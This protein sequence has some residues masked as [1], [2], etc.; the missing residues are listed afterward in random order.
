MMRS[1]GPIGGELRQHLRE[2]T[3]GAHHRI[4]HHR[5]M[6]P[7]IHGDITCREY[8][9]ILLALYGLHRPV[10]RALTQHFGEPPPDRSGRLAMDLDLIGRKVDLD[11]FEFPRWSGQPPSSWSDYAGM[12]YVIEGSAL[13]GQVI[14]AQLGERLPQECQAAT[15]FFGGRGGDQEWLEFWELLGKQGPI[16]A[17]DAAKAAIRLFAEIESLWDQHLVWRAPALDAVLT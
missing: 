3:K 14:R 1:I 11:R 5:L 9:N 10:E 2:T 16:N 13:G 4:D 12:R 15:R 7:L 17:Q 6:W 8:G